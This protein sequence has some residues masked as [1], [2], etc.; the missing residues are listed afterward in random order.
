MYRRAHSQTVLDRLSEPPR[1]LLIV[2]GPRQSGK[3]TLVRQALADQPRPYRYVAVDEPVTVRAAPRDPT[4]L[5]ADVG[6]ASP[7]RRD[8]RW[9]VEQWEAARAEAEQSSRGFVLILDGVKKM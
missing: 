7:G 9:L 6:T 8:A 1:L 2:S 4:S 3:T 5:T